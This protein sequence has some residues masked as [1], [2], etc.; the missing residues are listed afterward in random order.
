[1]D[2]TH[3]V[4]GALRSPA[5]T[6][7]ASSAPEKRPEVSPLAG[8][9]VVAAQ[10]PREKKKGGDSAGRISIVEGEIQAIR[11]LLADHPSEKL[12]AMYE[13]SI[14]VV[15]LTRAKVEA[16]EKALARS[17][18]L[19]WLFGRT[20]LLKEELEEAQAEHAE[21]VMR[22]RDI[23]RM[24]ER[25]ELARDLLS[26]RQPTL[27]LRNLE[28]LQKGCSEDLKLG[29]PIKRIQKMLSR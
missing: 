3:Q 17:G 11:A 24:S 28:A 22:S 6:P 21:A 20:A 25:L 1:M 13:H 7:V 29:E 27:A 12:G 14:E 23:D 8:L 15:D 26:K 5:P 2:I 18:V 16:A 19:D 4:V 10:M 9:I